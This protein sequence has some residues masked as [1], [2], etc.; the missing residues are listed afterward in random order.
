ML[1]IGAGLLYQVKHPFQV[2]CSDSSFNCTHR[3][4]HTA[5]VGTAL[6]MAACLVSQQHPKQQWRPVNRLSAQ[7]AQPSSSTSLPS[8]LVTS[9][10]SRSL[11]ENDYEVLLQ[12]D[13]F[14]PQPDSNSTTARGRNSSLAVSEGIVSSLRVEPLDSNHPLI[15]SRLCCQLC[16]GAYQRGDWVKKLPCKHK[17]PEFNTYIACVDIL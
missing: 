8:A 11:T 2:T 7:S 15:V 13:G 14:S 1:L 6:F 12:L 5:H 17:V 4:L 9:L 3:L 16:G 10:Q